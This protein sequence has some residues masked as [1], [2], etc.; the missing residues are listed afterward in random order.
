MWQSWYN[1]AMDA[2]TSLAQLSINGYLANGKI[3]A[4]PKDVPAEMLSKKAGVF[5]SL[6][7]KGNHELRGCIGTFEP[8]KKNIAEEIIN[9]AL[10]AAL[11]DPRFDP[12]KRDEMSGLEI[13]VDVL[14]APEKVHDTGQL[15]PK[16]YGLIVANEH[17]RRGLLLPDI[18]V[19]TVEE[20]ID[21][22]CDKD[23]ID[24]T[25][26]QLTYYRFIVERHQ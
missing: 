26:D 20:Q 15:D 1:K 6:H 19:A 21:I 17:G 3:I 12:V 16:K 7:Q 5:V 18:G 2:Y 24:R 23:G 22:C 9:N 4:V 11:D 14:S 13:G 25:K 10:S 8:T